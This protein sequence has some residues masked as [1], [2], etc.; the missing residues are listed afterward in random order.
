MTLLSEKAFGQALTPFTQDVYVDLTHWRNGAESCGEKAWKIPLAELGYVLIALASVVEAVIKLVVGLF[1]L[2]LIP[3]NCEKSAAA[4][5][6]LS[7][8]IFCLVPLFNSLYALVM[9]PCVCQTLDTCEEQ[10]PLKSE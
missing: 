9:N 10:E 4:C 7:S 8:A 3:C 6:L 5:M 1:F 2:A